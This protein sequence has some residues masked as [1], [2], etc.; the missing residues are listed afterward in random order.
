[1]MGESNAA[2]SY[3]SKR[4]LIESQTGIA[5]PEK[6]QKLLQGTFPKDHDAVGEDGLDIGAKQ[7]KQVERNYAEQQERQTYQNEGAKVTSVKQTH[8]ATSHD[9]SPN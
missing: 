5:V 9:D 7:I 2:L 6:L 4:N 1:M 3:T 8:E